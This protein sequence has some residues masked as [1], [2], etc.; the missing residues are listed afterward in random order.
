VAWGGGGQE[1]SEGS[2]GT[3]QGGGTQKNK[4]F[5]TLGVQIVGR[6]GT[7]KLG[8]PLWGLWHREWGGKLRKHRSGAKK[9]GSMSIRIIGGPGETKRPEP[10]RRISLKTG[11]VREGKKNKGENEVLLTEGK[12]GTRGV[13][14]KSPE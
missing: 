3:F 7:K 5:G 2:G 13:F 9:L 12:K 6:L 4:K 8:L 1:E 14:E 11:G 10:L